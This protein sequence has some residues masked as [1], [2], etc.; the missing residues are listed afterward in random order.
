MKVP[1]RSKG[2]LKV[3]S[4][5]SYIIKEVVLPV[6]SFM[7]TAGISGMVLVCASI[8]AVLWANSQYSSYYFDLLE[9]TLSV[10][11][12]STILS[13]DLKHFINDGLMTIFFFVVGLEI[14]REFVHGEL[15]DPKVSIL[16]IGAAIGG[17][18]FPALI[19]LS[20]NSQGE[21]LQGWGIPM[22]TDIAF[23]MAV[24]SLLGNRIPSSARILL[25]SLAIV[26][27]IGAI[28]VIA[29][30]YTG[31]ISPV[32]LGIG[33]CF[34]LVIILINRFGVFS[35][36]PYIFLGIMFWI[37]IYTSGIHATIAGV[38]LGILTPANSL[39]SHEKFIET[40]E[41][42]TNQIREAQDEQ[43]RYKTEYNI[44]QIEELSRD[45][46]SP[47]SRL[48]RYLNPWSSYLV[49]PV[50]AFVNAGITFS[51]GLIKDSFNSPILYGIIFGLLAGKI[52]GVVGVSWILVRFKLAQLPDDINWL[53]IFGIGIL[54]GIGFTVSLFISELAFDD[55]QYISFA[56][57]GIFV[58]SIIAGIGGYILLKISCTGEKFE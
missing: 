27:D 8:I 37:A 43:N 38:I 12:G 15:S 41:I 34:I 30:F 10:S 46:E 19:Y 39:F 36:Y 58:A 45:T 7:Y 2:K 28:L 6:Q 40:N 44:G 3:R 4:E 32:A 42:L 11:V 53:H 56:K 9:S 47:L 1:P 25:L 24:L 54:A 51:E 35:F 22:A 20:F 57:I 16:P 13:L 33:V 48:L 29:F 52:I 55:S 23:A 21:T 17:M 49:L 5:K 18:V 31:S 26:D 14:K 50:F